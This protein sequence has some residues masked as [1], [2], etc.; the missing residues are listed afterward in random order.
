[1]IPRTESLPDRDAD[2]KGAACASLRNTK[3]RANVTA[4]KIL[5][6]YP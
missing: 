4:K 3:T 6:T 5:L 1:M 2:D